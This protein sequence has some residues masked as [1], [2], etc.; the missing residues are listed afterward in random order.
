M[1]LNN[2]NE[3]SNNMDNNMENNLFIPENYDNQDDLDNNNN[4]LQYDNNTMLM[5]STLENYQENITNL[6]YDIL[7]QNNISYENT[8]EIENISNNITQFVN[9]VLEDVNNN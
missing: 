7:N 1:S 2:N 8:E 5:L 6:Q 4:F 3:I 9:N